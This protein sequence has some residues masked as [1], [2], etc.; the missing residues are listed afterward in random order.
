MQN[1]TYYTPTRVVFGKGEVERVGE[2]LRAEGA[3]K[4]LIHYGG[5]PAAPACWSGWNGR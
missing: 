1:F 2:L 4:V 3:G 5:A